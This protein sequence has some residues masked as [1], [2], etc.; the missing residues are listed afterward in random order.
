MLADRRRRVLQM[1]H[2][3]RDRLPDASAIFPSEKALL[4]RHRVEGDTVSVDAFLYDDLDTD[5]LVQ[6]GRLRPA[7]CNSCG[8][9]DT[10]LFSKNVGIC[11]TCIFVGGLKQY[12]FTDRR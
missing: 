7:F 9:S 11:V 4:D 2:F 12:I 10:K 1:V 6:E 8:S 5:L 3:L